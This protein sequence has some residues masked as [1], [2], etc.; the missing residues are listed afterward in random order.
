[1]TTQP[2]LDISGLTVD[3]T[4]ADGVTV[5]ALRGIDLQLAAGETYAL[6]GESGSGKSL[7]SLAI[8]GLIARGKIGGAIRLARDDGG[9]TDLLSLSPQAMTRMRGAEVA[10]IFQ[11]PMTSLNP[12][13]TAGAQIGE[14]LGLHRGLKGTALNAAILECLAEVEIPDPAR[15]AG[16][17]PHE[18]SGGMRQRVLIALALASNPRL[19]IADEPTT[20]LD[21]T[22]QAQILLLL[23][24]IQTR[25]GMAILFITH[26]LA[27]VAEIAARVGVMYGGRLVEEAP[28]AEV[29]THPRHPY[30]RGLL[31]SMPAADWSPG[32]QPRLNAIPGTPVDIRQ[33]PPGCGFGPRCAM[34]TD[35]CLA[36]PVPLA[37][38]A[39]ARA[40]R[41]LRWAEL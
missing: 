12:V 25:R 23:Q 31:R 22:V 33:P 32:R 18:L 20:A 37:I 34:V 30:T 6:V 29:F 4:G 16:A 3:F 21:V 39:P 38:V 11:E 5:R 36:A 27:V 19:L 40:S 17:Y 2:L 8:M 15:R 26:S 9:A 7:T 1:M 10:M 28:V 24:R 13:Q 35:A 14:V 41:C